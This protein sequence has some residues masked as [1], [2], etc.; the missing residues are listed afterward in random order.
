MRAAIDDDEIV[1]PAIVTA[2]KTYVTTGE[3]TAL[4]EAKHGTCR[5]Q[6]GAGYI[7]VSDGPS[8]HVDR[9]CRFDTPRVPS[10]SGPA[11]LH[12][13]DRPG[14]ERRYF[15]LHVRVVV[16]DDMERPVSRVFTERYRP[17]VVT[18]F[19]YGVLASPVHRARSSYRAGLTFV[20]FGSTQQ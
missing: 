16:L 12:L 10:A 3:I 19:H 7:G 14:F 5:E 9:T 8:D 6:I 4:F 11:E 15:S 2:G 13:D 18:R 17:V 1:M 20:W